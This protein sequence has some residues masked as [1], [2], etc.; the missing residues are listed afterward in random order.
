MTNDG[1]V[2]HKWAHYF[3]VYERHFSS[4]QGQSLVFWEVGVYGGGSL[5]MWQRYFGPNA[6][7]VGL[8]INSRCKEHESPGIHVRIGD[9]ASTRFLASVI[10]EFGPPDALLDDGSHHMDQTWKLFEFVYPQMLKN[11]VYMVEDMH[12]SYWPRWGGGLDVETSFINRSKKLID[13]LNADH[14]KG[15]LEPTDFTRTTGSISFYDS[16]VVFEKSNIWWKR[17]FRTGAEDLVKTI[18]E[19]GRPEGAASSIDHK[20]EAPGQELP[21]RLS[22]ADPENSSSGDG[23][24]A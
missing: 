1:K 12:T 14:S 6:I 13:E 5:Q 10:E 21:T 17:G 23:N 24:D 15:A 11:S 16:I 22:D 4:W 9:Q 20:A 19:R 2:I 8:D 18:D 7:I 3:P